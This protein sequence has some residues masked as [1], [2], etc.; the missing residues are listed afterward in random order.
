M[1]RITFAFL[2]AAVLAVLPACGSAGQEVAGASAASTGSSAADSVAGQSS[3]ESE[4]TSQSDTT[5]PPETGG[6]ESARPTQGGQGSLIT[7][8]LPIGANLDGDG[9]LTINFLDAASEVPA[10]V[11]LV[12][13][14][15]DFDPANAFE[16]VGSGCSSGSN[17]PVCRVGLVQTESSTDQCLALVKNRSAAV[18]DHVDVVV[19]ARVECTGGQAAAC[20][21][22]KEKLDNDK[23][24]DSGSFQVPEPNQ[25]ETTP[26]DQPPPPSE[27]D[28]SSDS[29]ATT[30]S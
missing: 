7:A 22:Y 18:N 24:T 5:P 2:C 19:T 21:Q 25:P 9:C 26:T 4:S 8:S 6:T 27:S 28:G 29:G 10:D 17:T 16:F 11:R 20:A 1:P 12:V 13:T 3:P 15:I 23:K 30:S 14:A